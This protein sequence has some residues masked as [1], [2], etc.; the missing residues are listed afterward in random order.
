MKK[1]NLFATK[2]LLLA[3]VLHFGCM[4]IYAQKTVVKHCYIKNHQGADY[5]LKI[6]E[7]YKTKDDMDCFK[8]MVDSLLLWSEKDSMQKKIKILDALITDFNGKYYEQSDK[9]IG[10]LSELYFDDFAL[11][12]MANKSSLIRVNFIEFYGR[13]IFESEQHD[14]RRDK[15]YADFDDKIA[16]S[17]LSDKDKKNAKGFIHSLKFENQ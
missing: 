9:M 13:H 6:F 14:A 15:F 2:L 17:K 3:V 5:Y 7:E 8:G 16:Q 10:F 4:N 1:K 11:Y 12:M